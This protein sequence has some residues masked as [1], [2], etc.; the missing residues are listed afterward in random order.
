MTAASSSEPG[1]APRRIHLYRT[2]NQLGDLLLNVPAIRAVRDRYPS[3]HLTLIVG[4]Q[5]ASA[6]L[7]QPWADEVRVVDTKNFVGMLRHAIRPKPRADLAIYFTTV[8]YSRSG[9]TLVRASGARERVGFDPARYD[10]RD[11]ARL[12]RRVAYPGGPL[13]QSEVSG[14]LAAAIGAATLPPPPYFVAEPSLVERAPSGVVY[15]H[16]GAGKLK[17]R[18][19][20]DR[21]GAVA[22]E[23][24]ARRLDVRWIAGP[25]DEGTVEAAGAALSET[26]P[27]VRNEPI[28]NLAARFAKAALYI[29]ND[30]GPLH[31]AG[32]TGCPTLGIYGWSDPREWAPVGRCVRHVRAEDHTLESIP[33]ERVLDQALPLI[34][35]ERCAMA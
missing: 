7:G 22:R 12:T 13:H 9:A 18:W 8:S 32:A 17:N 10:E 27:V 2:Q 24:R 5:N 23:L 15:L 28:P 33:V 29:G 20:A 1:A 6:V 34:Q 16:P 35:E 14:A 31:L 11:R 3:S 19:P 30:T 21:F 26:L 4:T 25:Q